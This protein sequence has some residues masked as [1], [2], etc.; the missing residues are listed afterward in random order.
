MNT[1]EQIQTK[2]Q[3]LLVEEHTLVLFND[4]DN[5]FDFVIDVLCTVCAHTEE[6]AEQCAWIAHYK[7]KCAVM[8][9]DIDTLNEKASIMG[10]VGLTVQVS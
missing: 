5:S 4:H 10:D 1:Q 8:S 2:P 9:G 6:Q 7:G 3:E